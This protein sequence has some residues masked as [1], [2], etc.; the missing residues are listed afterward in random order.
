MAAPVLSVVGQRPA[1]DV[2]LPWGLDRSFG[3]DRIHRSPPLRAGGRRCDGRQPRRS[4]VSGSARDGSFLLLPPPA[5]RCSVPLALPPGHP[6]RCEGPPVRSTRRDPSLALRM[7][8]ALGP[9]VGGRR[10][11]AKRSAGGGIRTVAAGSPAR[12]RHAG[13]RAGSIRRGSRTPRGRSTQTPSSSRNAWS[14]PGSC[15]CTCRHRRSGRPGRSA[16]GTG[17]GRCRG[18]TPDPAGR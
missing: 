1:G 7:T 17:T 15:T 12:C 3:C 11:L 18:R 14:P 2:H 9:A 4:R 16:P 6:E 8:E 5:E 10:A 13:R